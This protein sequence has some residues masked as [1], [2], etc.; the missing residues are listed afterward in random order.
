[1]PA[2]NTARLFG[3]TISTVILLVYI[4]CSKINRSQQAFLMKD[5]FP[6]AKGNSWTYDMTVVTD[7]EG[8]DYVDGDIYLGE[9]FLDVNND[10]SYNPYEPYTDMNGNMQW[11]SGEPYQDLN[12]NG[13]YDDPFDIFIS[14][15]C[16]ENQDLNHNGQYDQGEP[17]ADKNGNGVYDSIL[18]AQLSM[19]LDMDTSVIYSSEEE[20]F[21]RRFTYYLSFNLGRVPV[22]QYLFSNDSNGLRWWGYKDWT[23][24]R[25]YLRE[26]EPINLAPSEVELG[27]LERNVRIIS[28]DGITN[29][30]ATWT[31]IFAGLED[32]STPAG[33]FKDCLR[34]AYLVTGWPKEMSQFNGTIIQWY[35]KGIGL[36]KQTGPGPTDDWLLR[37]ANVNGIVYP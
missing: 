13:I 35:A 1:M 6:L 8:E 23:S 32:I 26:V 18:K 17:F 24:A 28:L 2:S 7:F 15:Y 19:K 36:V 4:S 21:Y 37:A 12:G 5:Y 33:S 30:T 3:L 34:F 11:D 16:P 31:S 20:V 27:Y 14:C 22:Y 29:V 25:D 9:P 10:W